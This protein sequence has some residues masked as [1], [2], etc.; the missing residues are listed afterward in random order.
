[1]KRVVP[2]V[3][4][5][6][7]FRPIGKRSQTFV[8]H[9]PTIPP[10][11]ALTIAACLSQ[12]HCTELKGREKEHRATVAQKRAVGNRSLG[13]DHLA[14]RSV[15]TYPVVYFILKLAAYRSRIRVGWVGFG[16]SRPYHS[17]LV[18][19]QPTSFSSTSCRRRRWNAI[20]LST[21]RSSPDSFAVW[22]ASFWICRQG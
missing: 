3:Y 8:G 15:R 18:F 17:R 6:R 2:L 14:R 5:C 4:R 1:M 16:Y 19:Q 12:F 13:D 21:R 10:Q 22:A 7:R 11:L 20:R 9:S